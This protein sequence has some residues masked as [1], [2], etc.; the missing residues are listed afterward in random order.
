MSRNANSSYHFYFSVF[1]FF[2]V[3]IILP[4]PLVHMNT[5]RLFAYPFHAVPSFYYTH[6]HPR[7]PVTYE[8]TVLSTRPFPLDDYS[9]YPHPILVHTSLGDLVPIHT[10]IDALLSVF[11]LC[12]SLPTLVVR[13]GRRPDLN[14][15]VEVNPIPTQGIPILLSIYLH[16][17]SPPHGNH[18]GLRNI[19]HS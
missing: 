4:D 15:H 13:P 10:L 1:P 9:S 7:K 14:K 18:T 16:V 5:L 17:P 3:C 19:R 2:G 6:G 8:R 11:Y 12:A